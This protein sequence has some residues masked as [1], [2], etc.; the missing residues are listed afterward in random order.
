LCAQI[1]L[2]HGPQLYLLEDTTGSGKTEA[3]L[4][5]A[6]RLL[7]EGSNGEA[8]EGAGLYI[9]LPT[10]ATSNAMFQRMEEVYANFFTEHKKPSL[11]LAHGARHLSDRF[12]EM[13][14]LSQQPIDESYQNDEKTATGWC[15][16]WF[17]D[18]RKK[19]LL[20]DVGVGTIDQALL[21]ILPARHQSLR[22][23]G[24]S[25]KILIVDE[26]H[27]YGKYEGELIQTLIRFHACL[28]G[29]TI[30]LSATMPYTLRQ[31]LVKAY[32]EGVGRE[33]SK[34]KT[35]AT[36]PW[37]TQLGLSKDKALVEKPVDSRPS[38]MRT[39]KVNYQPNEEQLWQLVEASLKQGKSVCWI[40]NTVDETIAC[41]DYA[42]QRLEGL[43]KGIKL[44]HSRFCM[45]DRI[46]T[47]T[48]V[49]DR[50]G[51][52]SSA[53]KRQGQFLISSPILDQSLDADL[54][55]M[56]SDVAPMD[57]LIQRLGRCCRHVRDEN[58]NIIKNAN[59]QTKDCRDTPVLYLHGPEF[60]TSPTATWLKDFSTGIQAIYQDTARI[61]LTV[62]I[63]L[64]E[65][66]ISMPKRARHLIE[67][68]YGPDVIEQVPDCLQEINLKVTGEH[69]SNAFMAKFNQ[70]DIEQGYCRDSNVQG[71]C[72]ENKIPTRLI[73]DT[74]DLILLIVKEG[75]L[76]FYNQQTR[77][78]HWFDM[79]K[80]SVRKSYIAQC[81]ADLL[82]ANHKQL[83]QLQEQYPQLQYCQP[84]ILQQTSEGQYTSD[85]LDDKQNK[86]TV[87]YDHG[88]GL[89]RQVK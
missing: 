31:D 66:Q 6:Q 57:V 60:T 8:R 26:V 65:K 32:S 35:N 81:S 78:A 83:E 49:L 22:L 51:K 3:A 68:V 67:S 25:R 43:A 70:L 56:I 24:V 54:T 87:T 4:I 42:K 89:Q 5:L 41:Y 17:V 20:A 62:K 9:A 48:D 61:W 18:N 11:V 15:N 12:N 58:E 39:V 7:S 88:K 72:D 74:T 40:K 79:S 73:D 16:Y 76:S 34:I 44:F 64:A 75:E 45:F 10:M 71:W 2:D 52:K 28:G 30:L 38:V 85:A 33:T 21:G 55:V 14:N 50:F 86:Y 46:E 82:A 37:F 47:E 13:V 80:M 53:A 23:L 84:L 27:S 19:S 1:P 69:R 77:K 63:L 59:A 29:T 36:F